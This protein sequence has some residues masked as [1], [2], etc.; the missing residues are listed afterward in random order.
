M[1]GGGFLYTTVCVHN[2]IILQYYC[3][4][5]E[6]AGDD[7]VVTNLFSRA[8]GRRAHRYRFRISGANFRSSSKNCVLYESLLCIRYQTMHD[9]VVL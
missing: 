2:Y 7:L 5:V 9:T 8:L 6:A 3:E 1:P 4:T